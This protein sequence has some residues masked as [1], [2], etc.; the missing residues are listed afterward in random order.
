MTKFPVPA[1]ALVKMAKSCCAA[2]IIHSLLAESFKGSFFFV[3]GA[4]I[5]VPQQDHG[6]NGLSSLPTR[7]SFLPPSLTLLQVRPFD[8]IQKLNTDILFVFVR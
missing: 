1:T 6:L 8:I 7:D 3:E 2:L 5:I 4:S